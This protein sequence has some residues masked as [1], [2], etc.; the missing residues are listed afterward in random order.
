GGREAYRYSER[1]PGTPT[2]LELQD[3]KT[4]IRLGSAYLRL[5]LDRHFDDIKDED[6]RVA[7]ALAAYNWGP[8]RMR[9]VLE[10]D[11]LPDSV[12]DVEALLKKHA[13]AETR[14]YVREITYRMQAFG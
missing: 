8:T 10:S 4:N 1:K 6:V 12:N 7:V 13:P 11:G 2:L 3:P 14:D 9:R 5:L